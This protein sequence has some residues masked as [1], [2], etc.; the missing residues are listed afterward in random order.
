M[1]SIFTKQIC[2]NA[3]EFYYFAGSQFIADAI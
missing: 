1:E 3:Y 2:Q